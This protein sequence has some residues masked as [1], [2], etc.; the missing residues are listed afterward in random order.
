MF[1]FSLGCDKDTVGCWSMMALLAVVPMVFICKWRD[2]ALAILWLQHCS[3]ACVASH[4][5]QKQDQ[6]VRQLHCSV[7]INDYLRL[8]RDYKTASS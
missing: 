6:A 5:Q 3:A 2:R 8:Y 1:L 4:M 7:W